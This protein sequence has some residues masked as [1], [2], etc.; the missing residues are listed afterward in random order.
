[1][2][3]SAKRPYISQLSTPEDTTLLLPPQDCFKPLPR[4]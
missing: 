1:M 2:G 3:P 4:I